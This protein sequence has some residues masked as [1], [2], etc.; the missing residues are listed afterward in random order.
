MELNPYS[1]LLRKNG[2]EWGY[3]SMKSVDVSSLNGQAVMAL[4][5]GA[6]RADRFCEEALLDL[7]EDGRITR[8]IA[9]L[10][11]LDEECEQESNPWRSRGMKI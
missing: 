6:I 2:I 9:R 1:D 5:F 7:C 10:K 8:W 11:E 3:D 4:I